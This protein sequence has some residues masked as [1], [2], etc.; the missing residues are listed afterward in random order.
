MKIDTTKDWN[1]KIEDFP[2]SKWFMPDDKILY[3]YTSVDALL[4]GIIVKDKPRPGKEIC[5][6]ATNC[7]YMN[8]P[9]ELNT[10][11]QFAN[12]VLDSF[13][14]ESMQDDCKQKEEEE[15]LKDKT[16]ITSFS[17]AVD[18]LPMWGMYG[19]N[20]R[21]L[22]LGFDA[23]VLK[24]S[25]NL[26]KCVYATEENEKWLKE[27]FSKWVEAP[28]D[29]RKQMDGK[30]I[31]SKIFESLGYLLGT[32]VLL[33]ALGKHSAYVYE[34]EMRSMLILEERNQ[35]TKDSSVAKKEIIKYRLKN[36][37]IV[38]YVELYLP[39]SALKEIWI[40]PTNDMERATKSLRIYLD[41]MGFNEVEIKQS[42]VPYRD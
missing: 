26:L 16:Y 38:P 8:D 32:Y 31:F 6:W 13:F 20:G 10:G 21:G 36:N 27:E 35:G 14:D 5:L 33:W 9:E 2:I 18:C 11:I 22:A 39:K 3:H 30:N 12:K 17:S 15:R 42:K 37:L 4:G 40:G 29:W 24:T 7:R 19:Q 23:A 34:K 25:F 41:H 28:G 1:L